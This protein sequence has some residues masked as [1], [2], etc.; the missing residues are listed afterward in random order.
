MTQEIEI[1]FKNI[2]TEEEFDILCRSFSIEAFTKQVNHYFET[3]GF[4]LKE[5]GS[6]LRIRHKGETYTLTLKQPAEIGLLETHQV[7][8]ADEARLMMETNTIIQG[9]VV[10]QLHKL[11]IPVSS[12]TYMGNLTTER[13]E[14]LFEGGTL[15][16]D[17]SFYYNHDDYEIE[18]EVQDEETGKAAFMNLLKQHNIP[19]RHTNNK[20]KR[21]FLAK[22]NKAR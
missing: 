16:F 3:P 1:E 18:Y 14:T 11:Q 4:S 10:D 17:H 8:T 9:D 15:V 19:V 21:F 6:A 12:L 13:A 20:V 22:Q 5:T 7:V 2:V